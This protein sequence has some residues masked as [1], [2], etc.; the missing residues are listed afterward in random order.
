M[1]LLAANSV[2]NYSFLDH[3]IEHATHKD[4][5]ICS[6]G[7]WS[8]HKEISCITVWLIIFIAYQPAL[9]NSSRM[10]F[11]VNFLNQ[12]YDTVRT[13]D[14]FSWYPNYLYK[15][16]CFYPSTDTQDER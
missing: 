4:R 15:R 5:S 13:P 16:Y 7:G 9:Q 12:R 2:K 11:R 6:R 8:S 3:D 14:V 1:P 10:S